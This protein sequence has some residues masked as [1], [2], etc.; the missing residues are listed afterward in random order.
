MRSRTTSSSARS[1]GFRRLAAR[2]LG[3]LSLGTAAMVVG[4]LANGVA[5]AQPTAI[6]LTPSVLTVPSDG[7][8]QGS[9]TA[10]V[11]PVEQGITVTGAETVDSGSGA[12][13]SCVTNAL[14]QCNLL[15]NHDASAEVGTFTASSGGVNSNAASVHFVAPGTVPDGVNLSVTNG[16]VSSAPPGGSTAAT[17]SDGSKYFLSET[18]GNADNYE[19]TTSE[20]VVT[21]KLMHTGTPLAAGVMPY[22]INWVITNTNT[23]NILYLDAVS[24]VPSLA[25]NPPV[26]NVVCSARSLN[27]PNAS[28]ACTPGSFDL[29]QTTHFSNPSNVGVLNDDLGTVN[30]VGQGGT[31]AF[32]QTVLPSHHFTFTTYMTGAVNNAFVVLSSKSAHPASATVSAQVAQDPYGTVTAGAA[33]GSAATTPPL[34]WAPQVAQGTAVTGIL[35][36]W[37]TPGD[38]WLVLN[39]SGAIELANFNAAAAQTYTAAGST[40][41]LA[42]FETDATGGTFPTYAV[43]NY[44][45]SGQAN[46]LLTVPLPTPPTPNWGYWTVASDGGIFSFG[47]AASH[48]YGSMGGSHLNAPMVG[49]SATPDSNGYWTVASDGGIFSFGDAHF[50]G[51]MGGSHL[52][53]PMVGMVPTSTGNGYWTV[54]SDGGVFSFGD[55]ATRFFGSMGGTHLNSPVVG[56]ATTPDGNGYWMVAADGGI[57]AFGDAKF[58]GSMG[59]SHLNKP[60]VGMDVTAD[61]KG[62]WLV[63]SDGG[64]FAFGD[65]TYYGSMGGTHINQPMVGIAASPS[66]NGYWTVASDGGIFSFGDAAGHFFGSMGGTHINQPMVGIAGTGV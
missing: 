17:F 37:D 55:A 41:N 50:F 34:V 4:P 26:N 40:V 60:V 24:S 52:N 5:S 36:A 65:A 47:D 27:D 56:M 63:A 15:T 2:T 10:T 29:D 51:S 22:A 46:A 58:F 45:M 33:I 7:T 39:V 23:T 61:G 48:F 9:V 35:K 32:T 64:I 13:A 1:S 49:M 62:Y 30:G 38:D 59:G 11:S 16:A 8:M 6:T 21:A 57:F 18:T 42:T 54:A 66:G 44:G 25:G 43:T 3:V 14:G 12:S 20:S 19:G 31:L 28:H 53:K